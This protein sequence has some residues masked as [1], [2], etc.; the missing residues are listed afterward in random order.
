MTKRQAVFS[1]YRNLAEVLTILDQ[2]EELS[3]L[4]VMKLFR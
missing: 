2:G 1:Y 3:D 4:S